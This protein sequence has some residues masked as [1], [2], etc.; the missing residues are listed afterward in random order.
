MVS[1]VFCKYRSD[2]TSIGDVDY[3]INFSGISMI[4]RANLGT[5]SIDTVITIL[6][7]IGIAVRRIM[8]RGCKADMGDLM[9]LLLA[10]L[11]ITVCCLLIKQTVLYRRRLLA[12][13]TEDCETSRWCGR[14]DEMGG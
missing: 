13:A 12:F 1:V 10:R 5:I 7:G 2:G 3:N 4:I 6:S 14:W 11:V 9:A 8:R